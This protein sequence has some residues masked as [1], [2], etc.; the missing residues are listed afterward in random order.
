MSVNR[1]GTAEVLPFVLKDEGFFFGRTFDGHK[2]KDVLFPELCV[3]EVVVL[4]M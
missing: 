4:R 3:I 1:G 2:N